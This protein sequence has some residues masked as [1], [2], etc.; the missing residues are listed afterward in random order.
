MFEH[1]IARV[2]AYAERGLG[3]RIVGAPGSG[4]TSVARR[5]IDELEDE[6]TRVYGIFGAPS[7]LSV[8]FAGILSLGLDLRSRAI[9]ILG[10]SDL[11]SEQL[12]RPGPRVLVVD[13]AEN[14]D[15]ESLSVIDIVQR[16]TQ[17]PL[18]VTIGESPLHLTTPALALGRLPQATV[19]IPPLRYDQ[20]NALAATMLGAAVDVDVAARILTKSGGNLRL[21]VRIID[22]AVLSERLV[23]RD[24]KWRMA[25]QTLL[26]EHLSST[27]E[28]L[29]Q[30]ISPEEFTALS[31]ISLRGPSAVDH[32]VHALGAEVLDGLEHRGLVSVVPG[33]DGTLLASVFPPVVEDYLKGHIGNS[34]QILRS[35]ITDNFLAPAPPPENAEPD[36]T[37]VLTMVTALRAEAKGNDF[38]TT[39]YFHRRLEALEKLFYGR[40]EAERSMANAAAFLRVYWGAP[41]DKFRIQSVFEHTDPVYH[42]PGDFLFFTMTKALWEVVTGGD[43]DHAISLVRQVAKAEPEWAAEAEASALFIEASYRGVPRN[44]DK[45]LARLK[46]RNP[47]S[48]IVEAVKGIVAVYRFNPTAALGALDSAGGFDMLPRVEPVI[49]GLALFASGRVDEALVHALE[50]RRDALKTTD[51]FSLV[52]HSYVAAQALLYRGL[53][54]E[55]EY[56]MGWVFSLRRPGFLV[57]SLHNAM[58]RLASLRGGAG[59]PPLAAQADKETPAV[60]PLPGTGTG[61]YD[62][63]S[64]RP[65]SADWFDDAASRLVDEQLERGYTFEAAMA[66]L[67]FLC[68]LPGHRLRERVERLHRST[69]AWRHDQL[70]AIADAVLSRDTRRLESLLLGYRQDG[71]VYQATML[72][73]G[74]VK[75]YRLAGEPIVAIAIERATDSFVAR[76]PTDAQYLVFEPEVLGLTLTG[77]EAEVALLAGSRTNQE[78]AEQLGLS[79][80]TVESHISNALRK[81]NT[82]TRR[83]LYEVVR[84]VRDMNAP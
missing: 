15:R 14:V 23:L 22:T 33:P 58:L 71:D 7:L 40:W 32:L 83:A 81:T 79:I 57:D 46:S 70:L 76:F 36:D 9:G 43:I 60:G 51:Q 3:V 73:R 31:T 53:F 62:L 1:E 64:R 41:I 72:L 74:A 24:G 11:L 12:S 37:S 17:V 13:D 35:A 6:G 54:D 61:V 19:P 52:A 20:I 44:V 80:R 16:R 28:E 4:R 56:L 25:G 5:V 39:R 47:T 48:G 10:V 45:I 34:R 82:T 59:I 26:N 78:I 49:R 65:V 63:V 66:G 77:R 29:L 84:D 69:K 67:F 55:A 38:A 27:V 21:A 30:G 42:D 8:P 2:L 50:R 18:I 68:L 75:R